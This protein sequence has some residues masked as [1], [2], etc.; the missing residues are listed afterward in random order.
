MLLK[1]VWKNAISRYFWIHAVSHSLEI[2]KDENHFESKFASILNNTFVSQFY[3]IELDIGVHVWMH[4]SWRWSVVIAHDFLL[5]CGFSEWDLVIGFSE[6]RRISTG[7]TPFDS[8]SGWSIC[9]RY[10]SCGPSQPMLSPFID[11]LLNLFENP[12]KIAVQKVK[13]IIEVHHCRSQSI[14]YN[15]VL[16]DTFA[17]STSPLL[18]EGFAGM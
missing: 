17:V 16:Y 9:S 15:E 12:L 13:D 14:D 1:C 18:W 7:M 3:L 4:I 10:C 2:T 11:V 6:I 5:S 8:D